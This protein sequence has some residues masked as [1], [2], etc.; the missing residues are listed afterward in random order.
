MINVSKNNILKNSNPQAKWDKYIPEPYKKVAGSMEKEFLNFMIT[1][2]N[3]TI[4]SDSK[5]SSAMDY[6]QGIMNKERSSIMAKNNGG[7]GIQKL[8]LDQI[9]PSH[10]RNNVTFKYFKRSQEKMNPQQVIKKYQVNGDI[11]KTKGPNNL[12]IKKEIRNE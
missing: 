9:Y 5:N 12:I 4:K 11:E 8:I 3:Q 6:Y 7:L 2:M 10:L 1:K